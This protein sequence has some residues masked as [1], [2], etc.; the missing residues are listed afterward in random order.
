MDILISKHEMWSDFDDFCSKRDKIDYR[1]F[2]KNRALDQKIE[3]KRAEFRNN[4]PEFQQN[5]S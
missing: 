4:G 2:E 1:I 5:W 3:R